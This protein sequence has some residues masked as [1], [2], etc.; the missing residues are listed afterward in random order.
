M[1]NVRKEALRQLCRRVD[2]GAVEGR[3]IDR[4]PENRREPPDP[5]VLGKSRSNT[6]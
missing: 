5:G 3:L 2:K 1:M 4:S 6:M